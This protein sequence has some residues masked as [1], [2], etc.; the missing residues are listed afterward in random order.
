M[1]TFRNLYFP[2][3]TFPSSRITQVSVILLQDNSHNCTTKQADQSIR[4]ETQMSIQRVT[5]VGQVTS[6][7]GEGGNGRAS[8][9]G[10]AG[11]KP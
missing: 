7:R 9:P 6:Q 8:G 2:Q 5:C 1:N 10:Q 4:I 11:G 3:E